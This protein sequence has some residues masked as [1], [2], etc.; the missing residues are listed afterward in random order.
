MFKVGPPP[1]TH[2]HTH[3]LPS[4]THTHKQTYITLTR[5]H[6]QILQIK[7]SKTEANPRSQH[8]PH[9]ETANNVGPPQL[10][11]L[12]LIWSLLAPKIQEGEAHYAKL[13]ASNFNKPISLLF[14]IQSVII[15]V[16][17]NTHKDKISTNT[18][19]S[20]TQC[21]RP[22]SSALLHST[23]HHKRSRKHRERLQT[24]RSDCF[25]AQEQ[26]PAARGVGTLCVNTM[27]TGERL[28]QQG[29]T[30]CNLKPNV[31]PQQIIISSF[32]SRERNQ[33]RTASEVI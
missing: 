11:P 16:C 31:Y 18:Q 6:F 3:M 19:S 23:L 14:I 26:Q 30:H 32:W 13:V 22:V 27:K 5:S 28:E 29:P 10:R 2:T 15:S 9:V 25:P 21:M 20:R 24:N 33:H 12:V 17:S 4:H 8:S 7:C 1:H